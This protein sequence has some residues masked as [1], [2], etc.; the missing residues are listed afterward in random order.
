MAIKG[1]DVWTVNGA[2]CG[3]ATV[4]KELWILFSRLERS[5]FGSWIIEAVYAGQEF[6]S[7]GFCLVL[8]NAENETPRFSLWET[9]FYFGIIALFMFKIKN[10]HQL[11][12]TPLREMALTI[13]EAGLSAID[14]DSVVRSRIKRDGDSILVGGVPFRAGSGRIFLFGVGKCSAE[15]AF[16]AES[17]LGDLLSGGIVLDVKS[18]GANKGKI[19]YFK[20]THPFPSQANVQATREMVNLLKN[21]E[22]RDLVIFIISGGGST[23]L[24][25]PIDY[26]N[27]HD[28]WAEEEMIL[29]RLFA[30][31][32]D[33]YEINTVRKHL[34]LARGG[35]LARYVFPARLVSLIFSDVP[36]NDLSFVA[37]GPTVRDET[38]IEDARKI[39]EKYEIFENCSRPGCG[40]IDTPKDEKY[41]EKVTNILAISN[42]L[43]LNAMYDE[44]R[45][46]GFKARIVTD[47]LSGESR[48]VGKKIVDEI[49]LEKARTCLL[50][51]GETTVTV[52]KKGRGGRNGEL[53]LSALQYV[54]KGELVMPVA[55]DGRDNGE[56]AGAIADFEGREKAERFSLDT[57][58]YLLNHDP[59]PFFEQ[60]GDY[61][62]TGHTGSNVSDLIIA[63]KLE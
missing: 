31:G 7:E 20:G 8:R 54:E 63:L 56:Y 18:C 28:V 16:A 3:H 42:V 40:L 55:S 4:S 34:S 32:A 36:G 25:L 19:K 33:I 10:I 24:C 27:G 29:K 39:L 46:H 41:F 14:T 6:L 61:I 49:R 5:R 62:M 58:K 43:A 1:S 44:A 57:E 48:D 17:V 38:K 52:D 60:T 50:Y 2:V 15:A 21:L 11:G 13:A 9:R 37:S 45:K 12:T 26:E 59:A 47:R 23:L 51:G 22:D 35:H 53:A 30:V